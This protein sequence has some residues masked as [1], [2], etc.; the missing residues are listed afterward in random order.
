MFSIIY[1]TN[2]YLSL[3]SLSWRPLYHMKLLSSDILI[4]L[5]RYPSFCPIVPLFLSFGL[6]D[7]GL[8]LHFQRPH[9]LIQPLL[10]IPR[11]SMAMFLSIFGR[12]IFRANFFY[13]KESTQLQQNYTQYCLGSGADQVQISWP[14]GNSF[15]RRRR[16]TSSGRCNADKI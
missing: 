14:W 15:E 9:L 6:K 2:H 4:S 1:L 16:E 11:E 10:S 5:S 8:R 3:F 13:R 7:S 12:G